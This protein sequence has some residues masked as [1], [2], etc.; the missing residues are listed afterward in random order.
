[1]LKVKRT[2]NIKRKPNLI[3]AIF[4]EKH[5]KKILSDLEELDLETENNQISNN[6]FYKKPYLLFVINYYLGFSWSALRYY[7][8]FCDW[9]FLNHSL[10]YCR[11]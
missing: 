2:K 8:Y 6:N 5:L 1:M 4:W 10:K 3:R 7:S 11:S 9:R